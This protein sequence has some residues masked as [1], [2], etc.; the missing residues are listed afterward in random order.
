MACLNPIVISKKVT[1]KYSVEKFKYDK[2]VNPKEP[3][4]M[5]EVFLSDEAINE[6]YNTPYTHF[7]VG[8]GKCIWCRRKR[9]NSWFVR[10]LCE[11]ETMRKDRFM[12]FVTLTYN[13]ENLGSHSLNIRDAQLFIKR[14]RKMFNG[15]KIKYMLVGEYG[16][17]THRKH[18][19]I[20]FFHLPYL[21]KNKKI[22]FNN[23]WRKGYIYTKLSDANSVYYILKYSLKQVLG[24]D[25]EFYHDANVKPP[26]FTCSKGIG[27]DYYNK[28]NKQIISNGYIKYKNFKYG[29]P[30]YFRKRAVFND[31]IIHNS[32]FV[33]NFNVND[34]IINNMMHIFPY[35]YKNFTFLNLDDIYMKNKLREFILVT[36]DYYSSLHN[37]ELDKIKNKLKEVA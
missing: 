14:V 3:Y 7:I 22:L 27:L 33:D 34:Y 5:P 15:E 18:Y 24:Y 10:T 35:S 8:C 17:H 31:E 12:Y 26:F 32:F 4:Y 1:N 23:L 28:H 2:I 25:K 19:H 29:I 16:M 9:I 13:N 37:I 6:Y 30:R 36:H 11:L 20:I 21:D